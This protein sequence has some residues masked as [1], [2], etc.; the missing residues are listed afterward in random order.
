MNFIPVEKRHRGNFKAFVVH[1]TQLNSCSAPLF[2]LVSAGGHVQVDAGSAGAPHPHHAEASGPDPV[3]GPAAGRVPGP[4]RFAQHVRHG[5]RRGGRRQSAARRQGLGGAE[6]GGGRA[7][8]RSGRTSEAS[9]VLSFRDSKNPSVKVQKLHRLLFRF[10]IATQHVSLFN[11]SIYSSL[12]FPQP[13][14]QAPPKGH[15]IPRTGRETISGR[16]KK[17][18][19]T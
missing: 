14:V 2:Y 1:F 4:R 11:F 17:N 13:M 9:P 3:P 5:V 8:R 7:E 6:G 16:E 15:R 19:L 18:I 10:L 12:V